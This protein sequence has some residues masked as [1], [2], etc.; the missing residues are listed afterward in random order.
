[1]LDGAG[2]SVTTVT[3]AGQTLQATYLT[4]SGAAVKQAR[5]AFAVTVGTGVVLESDSALTDDKGVATVVVRSSG[6]SVS[7]VA[8]VSAT[9]DT[10]TGSVNFVLSPLGSNVVS[11]SLVNSDSSATSTLTFG[12][13][14]KIRAMY[15]YA[16]GGVI[17]NTVVNFAI[18]SGSGAV[19]GATS[20]LTDEYGVAEVRV[21][22]TDSKVSGA[23]T[24]S[25]AIGS[26][27]GLVNF[28]V[29]GAGVPNLNLTVVDSLG[30]STTTVSYNGGQRIRAVYRDG[31][32]NPIA[33]TTVSFSITKGAAGTNLLEASALTDANGIAYVNV[34]SSGPTAT[35]AAT[36]SGTTG[37][38]TSTVDFAVSAQGSDVLA[39]SLVNNLG[40]ATSSV[41]YGGGQRIKAVFSDASGKGKANTYVQFNVSLGTGA[42]LAASSAITDASGV[43]Y[44][45]IGPTSAASVGGATVTGW[46]GN[47]VGVV[48]FSIVATVQAAPTL[49]LSVLDS[50]GAS[51]TTVTYNGGQK[52]R[53]VYLDGA[54]KPI[55]NTAVSFTVIKGAAGTVLSVASALTDS[56]GTAYVNVSSSGPTA[57]GAATVSSTAGI[58]TGTVDFAV[59]AQGSDLLTVSLVNSSD[60]QTG[61]LTYG[62]GQ[63]I[64]A[65]FTD[66]LGAVKAGSVVGFSVSSTTGVALTASSAVTN[67][68]GVAYVDIG[69]ASAASV[70]GATV[71]GFVGNVVGVVNF[72]IVATGPGTPTLSLSVLDS[73]D[74]STTTVTDNG[75]Q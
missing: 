56:T 72:S 65:V 36:I 57:A 68:S 52:I 46:V 15:K 66:S 24:V 58:T 53:A 20:A 45:D 47:V 63:R 74:S 37:V 40:S 28:R 30:N 16:N 35:G 64:K 26:V 19:L 51:T 29:L 33:K 1:V 12:G 59:S 39:V 9:S 54:N 60:A 10:V 22:A 27:T 31:A 75:G 42:T 32:N 69:P 8:T 41:T 25:A 3:S 62:A 5:V 2:K 73:S 55:A 50:S 34:S 44:V 11:L 18:T 43:A 61:Q 7:G 21:D 4:A 14:Q 71:T 48:N 70:G 49:S 67:S 13:G 17:P 6:S 38:T 23:V